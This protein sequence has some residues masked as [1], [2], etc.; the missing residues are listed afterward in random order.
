M[1][2]YIYIYIYVYTNIQVSNGGGA[3]SIDIGAIGLEVESL[4]NEYPIVIPPYFGLILRAFGALEGLGLS[5]DKD[6]SIVKECFP[7]LSRRLLSDD[8]ERIRKA[9]RTFLYGTKG[10]L[11]I[12]RV[13]ELAEGYRSFT[14]TAAAAASGKAFEELRFV[15]LEKTHNLDSVEGIYIHIYVYEYTYTYICI[16]MYMFIYICICLYIYVYIYIYIYIHM[17]VCLYIQ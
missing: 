11:D 3:F 8:S 13:D 9:L 12:D 6:Y 10:Q 1:C 15:S 14:A 7:Y 4:S 16:Y 2:I 17:Y 5:V